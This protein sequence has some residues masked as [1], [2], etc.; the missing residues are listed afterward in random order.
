MLVRLLPL[1]LKPAVHKHVA[2]SVPKFAR[3]CT[4]LPNQGWEFVC[5]RDEG[6]FCTMQAGLIPRLFQHLFRRIAEVE[7][8]QV[9]DVSCAALLARQHGCFKFHSSWQSF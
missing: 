6:R 5:M 7:K 4:C 9:W 2:R 1:F 8:A 3:A